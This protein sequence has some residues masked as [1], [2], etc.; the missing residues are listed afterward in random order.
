MI[1]PVC[2]TWFAS[3]YII[4]DLFKVWH[5]LYHKSPQVLCKRN[6]FNI[7]LRCKFIVD[8]GVAFPKF[9]QMSFAAFQG[10]LCGLFLSFSLYKWSWVNQTD[11]FQ[12]WRVWAE[13]T[14]GAEKSNE[15]WGVAWIIMPVFRQTALCLL[16]S[17]T[18][19]LPRNIIL[20]STAN[21]QC[22]STKT[23]PL[24]SSLNTY[25]NQNSSVSNLLST[26]SYSIS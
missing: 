17:C 8:S 14:A 11:F 21:S 13:I 15:P 22:S 9:A 2:I 6:V 10:C 12:L 24:F 25:M 23:G 7:H 26:G 4:V 5:T 1:S 3:P 18:P 20:L 16:F 19:H